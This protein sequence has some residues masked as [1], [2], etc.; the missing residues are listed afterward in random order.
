M[1]QPQK[2]QTTGMNL[3]LKGIITAGLILGLMIPA[4]LV[5][6]LI[7]ERR[8]RQD[9][10]IS[11]VSNK[12]ARSQ[13]ITGPYLTVP[14]T[15]E[16]KNS[17]G[18]VFT[19]ERIMTILPEKLDIN[20]TVLP[21]LKKR[22]IFQVALYKT[23]LV[24]SGTF[25]IDPAL[26]DASETIHWDRARLCLGVSDIRGIEK[27][28]TGSFNGAELT[29]ESGIYDTSF[30]NARG[31]SALVDL[32]KAD[33]STDLAFSIPLLLKG[34][35][36]FQMIPLGKT[37]AA[38]IQSEWTAPSFNGNFLPEYQLDEKGFKAHWNVLHFNRDFPQVWKNTSYK[39][40]DFS[41]GLS[42][43]QP[44]DSYAK[45]LRTSK[46][47]ILFLGLT[48]GFFYLLEI[49]L[50]H[51]VHP[52]QYVLTGLSLIIFYTLLLSITEVSSFNLAYFISSI[53]TIGLITMYSKHL[54]SVWKHAVIIGLFLAALYGYIFVLL[55]LE[56]SA[57]LAG[58]IGLFVLIGIAMY[59]SRKI[60]WYPD[61]ENKD[62]L[63]S[64]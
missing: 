62:L 16:E 13:V 29:F 21:H 63:S 60:N 34:S 10:V 28:P 24:L 2:K 57:L 49:L 45:V 27:Q 25:V 1:T 17:E 47:A 8:D 53:A 56:D 33:S 40:E 31:A 37:T 61:P 5:Q 32:S 23:D 59:L 39:A 12:W 35:E 58:S 51:R 55:Q 36:T 19:Y 52:V 43:L 50:G 54:F 26:A 15:Y 38:T 20:G 3:T 42:L 44:A 11:E 6:E 18:K 7:E 9:E 14:Y 41:F 30:K 22:S 46:Y 4:I 64:I 48:F